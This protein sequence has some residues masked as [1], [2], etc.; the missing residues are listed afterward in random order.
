MNILIKIPE[1]YIS[2]RL[3]DYKVIITIDEE[4]DAWVQE[5]G[6]KIFWDHAQ[7]FSNPLDKMHQFIFVDVDD[8]ILA[9]QFKLMFGT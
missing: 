3:N 1:K 2:S 4:I 8:D 6:S 9:V 5:T 7:I